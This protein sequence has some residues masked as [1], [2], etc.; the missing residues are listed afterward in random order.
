MSRV[1]VITEDS[2]GYF[3]VYD[4]NAVGD[5]LQNDECLGAVA[6][7]LLLPNKPLRYSQKVESYWVMEKRIREEIESKLRP[8]DRLL[9]KEKS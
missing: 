3:T 7:F 5:K 9:L 6:E 4:G 1:L 8:V 2:E